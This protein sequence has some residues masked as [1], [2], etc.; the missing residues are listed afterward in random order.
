MKLLKCRVYIGK[1]LVIDTLCHPEYG[2]LTKHSIKALAR[3]AQKPKRK[4]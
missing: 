2:P 1:T 4:K 3:E